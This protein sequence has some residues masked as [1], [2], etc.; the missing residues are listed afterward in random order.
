MLFQE[1]PDMGPCSLEVLYNPLS[2]F[3]KDGVKGI[4]STQV[5]K[6]ISGY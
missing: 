6:H 2:E 3:Q 4:D 1:F 5:Q